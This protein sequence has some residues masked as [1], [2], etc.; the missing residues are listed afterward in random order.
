MTN[1]AAAKR[2]PENTLMRLSGEKTK[3][4]SYPD[5][6]HWTDIAYGELV[7]NSESSL[8]RAKLETEDGQLSR[9]RALVYLASIFILLA[10]SCMFSFSIIW[11]MLTRALVWL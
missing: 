7:D 11:L 3:M 4:P 6:S 2:N 8:F 10:L 1:A 5:T 9:T